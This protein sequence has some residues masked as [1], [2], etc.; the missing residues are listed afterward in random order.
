MTSDR[1]DD[2]ARSDHVWPQPR[3]TD[4]LPGRV[5]RQRGIPWEPTASSDRYVTNKIP[6]DM[7]NVIYTLYIYGNHVINMK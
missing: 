2:G 3:G 6:R 5:L 7:G 4:A 1:S